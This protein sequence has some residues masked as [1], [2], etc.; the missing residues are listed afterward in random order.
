MFWTNSMATKFAITPIRIAMTCQFSFVVTNTEVVT[1][2]SQVYKD[3]TRGFER[4]AKQ[5]AHLVVETRSI[6]SS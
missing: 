2:N 5:E 1:T 3:S 4:I 6:T